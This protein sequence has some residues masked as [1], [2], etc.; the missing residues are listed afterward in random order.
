MRSEENVESKL[1]E[2]VSSSTISALYGISW[3]HFFQYFDLTNDHRDAARR[4]AMLCDGRAASRWYIIHRK[5]EN[6]DVGC[7]ARAT[8]NLLVPFSQSL[9]HGIKSYSSLKLSI[10]LPECVARRMWNRNYSKQ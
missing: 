4:C 9:D 2:T 10:N 8:G 7:D 1:F 6:S 3:Y 5:P